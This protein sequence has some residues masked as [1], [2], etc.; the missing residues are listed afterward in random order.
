M[1]YKIINFL[2][3][4][5]IIDE[6]NQAIYNYGLF[7]LEINLITNMIALVISIFLHEIEFGVFFLLFF[8]FLRITWGGYHTKHSVSCFCSFIFIYL[9]NLLAYKY[10]DFAYV[11]YELLILIIVVFFTPALVTRNKKIQIKNEE[12]KKLL[13][14]VF[15]VISFLDKIWFKKIL[16]LSLFT[17][18]CLHFFE[19]YRYFFGTYTFS[20]NKKI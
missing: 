18:V 5:N 2:I 4:K 8:D 20:E 16:I 10:Y 15:F 17:N 1:N 12:K 7:V 13:C 11:E 9:F 14:F 6:K 19:R 3:S